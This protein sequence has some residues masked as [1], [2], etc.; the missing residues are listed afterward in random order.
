MSVIDDEKNKIDCY[1]HMRLKFFSLFNDGILC[2]HI[3][4]VW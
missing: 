3:M 4:W 1:V 2:L